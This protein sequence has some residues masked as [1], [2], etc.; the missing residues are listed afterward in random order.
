MTPAA[1]ALEASRRAGAPLDVRDPL[2][3][4]GTI[5]RGSNLTAELQMLRRAVKAIGLDF[6]EFAEADLYLLSLDSLKLVSA[7][8]EA[9]LRGQYSVMEWAR[10]A[11]G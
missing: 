11:T 2:A 4:A 1:F 10:V 6:G 5:V 8:R 3:L 9:K 7:L